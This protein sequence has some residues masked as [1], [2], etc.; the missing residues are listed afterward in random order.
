[1]QVPRGPAA[2]LGPTAAATGAAAAGAAAAAAAA[3][4]LRGHGRRCGVTLIRIQLLDA[5]VTPALV[6]GFQPSAEQFRLCKHA[7]EP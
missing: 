1:M 2:C 3:P 5:G 7:V 4:G 6:G